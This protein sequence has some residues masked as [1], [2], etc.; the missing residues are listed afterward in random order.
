MGNVLNKQERKHRV[1]TK[2]VKQLYIYIYLLM[3]MFCY[4]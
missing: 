4:L 2:F 3:K 1:K